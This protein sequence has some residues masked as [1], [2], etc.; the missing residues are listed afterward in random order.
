[1]RD[2]HDPHAD[3][4]QAAGPRP[5]ELWAEH[6]TRLARE[7]RAQAIANCHLCDTDGYRGTT[8]CN[9][10]DNAAT[11]HRGM[12][13]IRQTMGWTNSKNLSNQK[14]LPGTKTLGNP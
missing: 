11:A 12:N 8:V 2:P 6:Q 3:E 4:R 5:D 9:H 7:H 14:P 10:T 1:M 13:Q